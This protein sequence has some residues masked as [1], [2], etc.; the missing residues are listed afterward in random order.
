[1]S[2][3]LP[4]RVVADVVSSSSPINAPIHQVQRISRNLEF[5]IDEELNRIIITVYEAE[6]NE[7]I[8]KIPSE[9]ALAL[10]HTLKGNNKTLLKIKA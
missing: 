9:E 8:R 2:N 7:I 6:T 1:M 4:I 10:M 3:D 5:T